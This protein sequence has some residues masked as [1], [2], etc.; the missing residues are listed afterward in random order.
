MET[1]LWRK[2]NSAIY[3][4]SK[5]ENSAIYYAYLFF[6]TR[7]LPVWSLDTDSLDSFD[8][9]QGI[10]LVL[11]ELHVSDHDMLKGQVMRLM[12][13]VS[14]YEQ[15]GGLNNGGLLSAKTVTHPY[16]LCRARPHSIHHLA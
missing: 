7:Y 6:L 11:F 8:K 12:L 16:H 10:W 14:S 4:I 9:E 13:H 5:K 1:L 2:E 15:D 3:F